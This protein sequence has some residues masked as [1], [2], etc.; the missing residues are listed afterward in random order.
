MRFA[1][2][3]AALIAGIVIGCKFRGPCRRLSVPADHADPA[4]RGRR[5]HGHPGARAVRAEAQGAPRQADRHREPHRR[6]HGDRRDRH[7]E[8]AARRL[9]AVHG[10]GRHAHH[11]R[12]AL[13]EAALRSGQGLHADRADLVGGLRAGGQSV[14]AGSFG[15]GADCLRQGAAR[16]ACLRLDR[17]RRHAASRVRDDD[18]RR[19]AEDDPRSL[20]RHAA[21]GERRRRQPRA[22]GVRRSGRRA[23]A[24]QGRQAS[25]ARGVVAA[26]HQRAAGRADHGRGR[27]SRA[28]RRCRGT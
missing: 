4:A 14:A 28:S 12:H 16:A 8:S 26:A 13:Q 24:D 10:A 19:R 18:A 20:S 5:R 17:H 23:A 15:Q 3:V 22:D 9:H 11:Q 21:G 25:S 2:F 7:G 6:R 27:A 1:R